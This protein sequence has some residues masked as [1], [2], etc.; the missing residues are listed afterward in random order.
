MLIPASMKERFRIKFE[1]NVCNIDGR[2]F[3]SDHVILVSPTK[4]KIV[5]DDNGIRMEAEYDKPPRTNN[6]GNHLMITT[7]NE[8][9]L[10]VWEQLEGEVIEEGDVIKGSG[11]IGIRASMGKHYITIEFLDRN[12]DSVVRAYSSEVEIEGEGVELANLLGIH[13]QSFYVKTVKNSK[14]EARRDNDKLKIKI[15]KV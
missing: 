7:S 1:N 12:K 10:P 2:S 4:I 8:R 5:M 9:Y 15:T 3:N 6:Y 14:M 13:Y 11:E